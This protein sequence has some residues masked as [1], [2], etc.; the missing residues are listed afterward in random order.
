MNL[1]AFVIAALGLTVF[2]AGC[3]PSDITA[4]DPQG[5]ISEASFSN[6]IVN[7][8]NNNVTGY[9]VTVGGLA[10][11]FAGQARTST[12][13]P[14][15]TELTL[16]MLPTEYINVASVS[17]TLTAIGVLQSITNHNWSINSLIAPYIYSDW[18]QGPNINTIT[19]EDLMTHTS[20]F[21]G[22]TCGGSNTTYAILKS[23]IAS[24]VAANHETQPPV[25][26]NCNFA[27]FRELLF[28]MEGNSIANL[29]DGQTRASASANF[30]V[31]Y[32]NQHVFSHF[33]ISG[34]GPSRTVT[35]APNP[36]PQLAMLAYPFPPGNTPGWNGG[37]DWTL[38]CG[39]GG[40]NLSAGDLFFVLNDIAGG[41]VLL[42]PTQKTQMSSNFLGWDNAVR[43]VSN[44]CPQALC[45]NGQIHN[46]SAFIW[47]YLGV[48][49]CNVPVVVLVN[50]PLPSPYQSGSDII[51]LV[52]DAYNALPQTGPPQSCSLGSLLASG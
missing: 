26:S 47:T 39:G 21:P 7:K 18:T 50:S 9:V 28:I 44:A 14:S 37:G 22:S 12:D 8:L 32:M 15:P 23:I 13:P 46:G 20:G 2:A 5:C 43:G 10:S 6:N 17:K 19:F 34:P 41:S 40:W 16:A 45:K 38:S 4:C 11:V 42:T 52:E 49:K 1:R 29:P 27:I 36:D 24:G 3:Q 25:Y 51:G 33:D 30:Y 31:S 35:C 48:F